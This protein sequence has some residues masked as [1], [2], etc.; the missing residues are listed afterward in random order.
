[1]IDRRHFLRGL[2]GVCLALPAFESLRGAQSGKAKAKRFVC[3]A[4]NY[5]MYPGSFFPEQ[6]GTD[7]A[8]P[9]ILKPMERHRSEF[10]IFNNLD[11]PGV[12]GGHG[13]SHTFLN[14]MEQ[15]LNIE[16]LPNYWQLKGI[17][18]KLTV[19]QGLLICLGMVSLVFM[20]VWLNIGAITKGQALHTLRGQDTDD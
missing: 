11:H 6:T 3:V 14:G 19:S 15:L 2:G 10:S 17:P 1:M 8:M 7:Y 16:I 9:S 13:C 20:A 18:F 4:P 12:G 5:G